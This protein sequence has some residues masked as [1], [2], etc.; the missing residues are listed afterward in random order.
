[1]V[2][3]R[4]TQ[5]YIC[6]VHYIHHNTNGRLNSPCWTNPCGEMG[7]AP[8]RCLTRP[9][10]KK[11]LPLWVLCHAK[12]PITYVPASISTRNISQSL[13]CLYTQLT[14]INNISQNLANRIKKLAE[15]CA[16]RRQAYYISPDDVITIR[17]EDTDEELT[18]LLT[19]ID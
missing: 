8:L 1:M 11:F 10:K 5:A 7:G 14:C 6:R 18:M 13:C 2:N 19:Y 15:F 16:R 9:Q 3:I 12:T 4:T 17:I